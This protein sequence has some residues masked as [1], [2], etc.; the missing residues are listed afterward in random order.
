MTWLYIDSRE[1]HATAFGWLGDRTT[2]LWKTEN[3]LA[4]LAKRIRPAELRAC[5]GICVVAGPGSFS[6]I[7][8]G[9]LVAN[10]MSRIYSLTLYPVRSDESADLSVLTARLRNGEIDEASYV[11]PEYDREPNITIPVAV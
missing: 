10:L 11:A 8:I 5:Q 7:R 9:V 1:R 2:K 3:L 6:S 4:D